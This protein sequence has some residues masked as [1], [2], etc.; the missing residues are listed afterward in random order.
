MYTAMNAIK[1]GD[2]YR[3]PRCV[4]CRLSRMLVAVDLESFSF[5][6]TWAAGL[7]TKVAWYRHLPKQQIL[8][9][10]EM[11][12][13]SLQLQRQSWHKNCGLLLSTTL[14]LTVELELGH[15]Q[16]DSS[17]QNAGPWVGGPF[18]DLSPIQICLPDSS[19]GH[20]Q[21]QRQQRALPSV[22]IFIYP[23]IF[24]FL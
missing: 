16:L 1:D 5:N 19:P 6:G 21:V 22:A 2:N 10:Q 8:V 12:L 3:R 7:L 18:P 9:A 14:Q 11:T 23:M 13:L 20:N 17:S 15:E 4:G 24:R